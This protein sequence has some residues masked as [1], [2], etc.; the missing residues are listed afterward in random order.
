VNKR[1]SFNQRKE[2]EMLKFKKT[3]VG[4]IAMSMALALVSGSVV[5][6]EE[7]R[8]PRLSKFTPKLAAESG[9]VS[10]NLDIIYGFG[11]A[12]LGAEPVILTAPDSE[13]R[14]LCGT[15]F[16]TPSLIFQ[17]KL[18]LAVQYEHCITLQTG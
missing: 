17:N 15:E 16:A 12:D 2:S 11:F 8:L 6:L 13:G 4:L 9:Y 14:Y 1:F 7:N 10:P 3:Q 5:A 18:N